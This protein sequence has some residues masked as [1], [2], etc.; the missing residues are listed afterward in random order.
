M[1]IFEWG[2]MK[3]LKIYLYLSAAIILSIVLLLTKYPNAHAVEEKLDQSCNQT[4]SGSVSLAG[5]G[6][7][8]YQIFKPQLNH[9]AAISVLLNTDG[10]GSIKLT[11]LD[12][13]GTTILASKNLEEQ[14]E[15]GDHTYRFDISPAVKVEP[16]SQ[17]K[18]IVEPTDLENE[19]L[20]WY[21]VRPQANDNCY[22]DGNP[23]VNNFS[24][25]SID[26]RFT[27]YGYN[28]SDSNEPTSN[29]SITSD[30]TSNK[31]NSS[32]QKSSKKTSVSKNKKTTIPKSNDANTPAQQ[33]QR[34]PEFLIPSKFLDTKSP[35]KKSLTAQ[36]GN[37]SLSYTWLYGFL[38]LIIL[39][40]IWRISFRRKQKARH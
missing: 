26:M 31:A 23:I 12:T 1:L 32:S 37:Q 8:I 38:A 9:L 3:N 33:S 6:Y 14:S 30:Q 15:S 18:F 7:I 25:K 13:N 22:A 11:L 35:T 5:D 20:K 40:G 34:L 39:A 24:D 28:S 27:T 29:S 19:N 10:N 2:T 21:Y 17:Y 36:K 4:S 16:D